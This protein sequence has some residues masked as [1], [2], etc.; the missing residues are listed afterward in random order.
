LAIE[1]VVKS[2]VKARSL[3]FETLTVAQCLTKPQKKAGDS[4]L[5][6]VLAERPT[7]VIIPRKTFHQKITPIP[8]LEDVQ[9]GQILVQNMYLSLDPAMRGWLVGAWRRRSKCRPGQTEKIILTLVM[10]QIKDTMFL[11]SRSARSCAGRSSGKSPLRRIGEYMVSFTG[12]SEYSIVSPD[13]FL[14]YE[15]MHENPHITDYLSAPSPTGLDAY[16]GMLKIGDPLDFSQ[17]SYLY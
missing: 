6:I 14:I 2:R 13:R 16:F 9:D 8:K 4:N 3:A 5:Q 7:G 1:N 17:A 12:R 15:S 11:P 10:I